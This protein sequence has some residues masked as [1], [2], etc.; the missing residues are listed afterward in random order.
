[1]GKHRYLSVLWICPSHL[2]QNEKS[3][4]IQ[5]RW[6]E[7]NFISVLKIILG[8][9][10]SITF[11]PRAYENINIIS[12]W[13]YRYILKYSELS[14]PR[15]FGMPKPGLK[16]IR[17]IKFLYSRRLSN[18][19]VSWYFTFVTPCWVFIH[20]RPTIFLLLKRWKETLNIEEELGEDI[21]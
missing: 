15:V 12:C 9:V 5:H 19:S 10:F 3:C 2:Y 7:K 17:N 8:M 11:A 13:Y 14:V 6:R 1:M 21:F 18:D 20:K 16:I 4:A